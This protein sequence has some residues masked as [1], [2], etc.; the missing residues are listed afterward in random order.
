MTPLLPSESWC[1]SEPC[2]TQVTISMSRCGCV[3]NP[4]PGVTMSSLL[5]RSSPWCV[6]CGSQ[7]LLNEKECFESSHPMRVAKRSAARRM[8]TAGVRVSVIVAGTTWLIHH[9]FRPGSGGSEL[10]HQLG[11][12]FVFESRDVIGNVDGDMR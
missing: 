12:Q 8:S 6:F 4:R 11:F 2:S 5:T 9:L 1:T 3:S 7:W 10:R